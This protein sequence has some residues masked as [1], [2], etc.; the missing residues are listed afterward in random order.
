MGA[1]GY[2]SQGASYPLSP[3]LLRPQDVDYLEEL[4]QFFTDLVRT[5]A[6]AS[7][8]P[9]QLSCAMVRP[10][11]GLVDGVPQL[12]ELNSNSALGGLTQTLKLDRYFLNRADVNDALLDVVT[13]TC[14]LPVA[15]ARLL[16]RL[17]GLT[18]STRPNTA[19]L[20]FHHPT[21]HSGESAV[22]KELVS[23]LREN[24]I[25]ATYVAVQDLEVRES[26]VFRGSLK[27]DVIIRT[28]IEKDAEPCGIDITALHEALR[29]TS[30][31][32]LSTREATDIGSKDTLAR[33]YE[34]L[35]TFS[36]RIRSVVRKHLP[37]TYLLTPGHSLGKSVEEVMA[38]LS[39]HKDCLVLKGAN[40]HSADSVTVGL[41]IDQDEWSAIIS[42]VMDCPE[43]FIAQKRVNT[44][45]LE[46]PMEDHTGNRSNVRLRSVF[47]P[48]LIGNECAGV[49]VR[50]S[51]AS[52]GDVVSA[53]TD[54]TANSALIG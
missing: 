4:S 15:L 18:G 45:L 38:T 43:N 5:S 2:R 17:A 3:I 23:G 10:D 11:F 36:P 41:E 30:T 32:V 39:S 53:F 34:N 9:N 6:S 19:I 14:S 7:D 26:G 51:P 35:N 13:T 47:G 24:G 49:L 21:D 27:L 50:H 25:P 22:Y 12:F 40:G 52:E 42:N 48:L 46:V 20:G 54:G 31:I 8:D 29:S 28:F 33:V 37:P 1:D 16:K 44:D